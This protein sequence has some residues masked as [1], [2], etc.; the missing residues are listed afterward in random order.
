MF[1]YLEGYIFHIGEVKLGLE[2]LYSA[3]LVSNESKNGPIIENEIH[4]P[5]RFRGCCLQTS[6]DISLIDLDSLTGQQDS[7]LS[8]PKI[9]DS[10]HFN[11][12]WVSGH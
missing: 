1:Y 7:I 8:E 9:T 6:T 11:V 12:I 2:G 4:N 10:R 5:R 3:L